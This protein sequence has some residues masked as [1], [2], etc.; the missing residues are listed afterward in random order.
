MADL[1]PGKVKLRPGKADLKS[2]E[3]YLRTG[4]AILRLDYKPWREKRMTENKKKLPCVES[5]VDDPFGP[6]PIK[7]EAEEEE[8][9]DEREEEEGEVEV[10]EKVEE[11]DKIILTK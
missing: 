3:V 2:K 5:Q 4:K 7:R 10:E 8:E 6:L 11:D 1:G 9:E